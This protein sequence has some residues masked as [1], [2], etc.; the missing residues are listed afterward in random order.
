MLCP[1]M[2][3]RIYAMDASLHRRAG[4]VPQHDKV[5]NILIV[6]PHFWPICLLGKLK[7]Y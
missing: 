6:A 7:N 3:R 1:P 5:N 4:G 2:A